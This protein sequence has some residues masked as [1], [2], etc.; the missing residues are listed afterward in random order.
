MNSGASNSRVLLLRGVL[1]E[2]VKILAGLGGKGR[3]EHSSEDGNPGSVSRLACGH[4]WTMPRLAGV[5]R[6]K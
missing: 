6:T 1:W 3:R 4:M 5:Y 2:E